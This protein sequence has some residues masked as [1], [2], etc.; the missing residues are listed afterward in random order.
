MPTSADVAMNQSDFVEVQRCFLEASEVLLVST[1]CGV[2][3][4]TTEADA[5]ACM[6]T[7]SNGHFTCRGHS[8]RRMQSQTKGYVEP[9]SEHASAC[10]MMLATHPCWVLTIRLLHEC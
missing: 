4:G 1:L 5:A 6:T 9:G 7:K 3:T 2:A 8:V 10:L